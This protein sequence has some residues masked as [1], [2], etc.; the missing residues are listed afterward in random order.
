M[1]RG[2]SIALVTMFGNIN[3]GGIACAAIALSFLLTA[4]SASAQPRGQSESADDLLMYF[5]KDPRT[6]RLAG[7]FDK[8]AA[9]PTSRNWNAYPPVAGFFAVVFQ[10]Q[11]SSADQL[12]PARPDAKVVE[13]LAAALRLS[14]DPSKAYALSLRFKDAGSDERLKAELAGL[15]TRLDDL[16]VITPSHL[17]ILWG[18]AFA[19]GDARYVR[20]VAD[21]LAQIA[22]RS[23]AVAVDIARVVLAMIGGPKDTLQALRGKY[24]DD[25]FRQIVYAATAAWAL[26]ANSRQHAFVDEAVTKYVS[27]RSGTPVAKV[28]SSLRRPK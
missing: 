18:A 25:D 7:F 14:G 11:P 22:N 28:L 5:Y 23:E 27:E 6:E 15:P 1:G 2:P 20:M 8:Y 19:S 13:V 12:I 10:K 26:L 9:T 17:D 16:R 4:I 24:G 21:F 3:R